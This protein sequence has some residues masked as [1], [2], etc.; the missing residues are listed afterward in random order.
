MGLLDTFV[1]SVQDLNPEWTKDRL[2]T[3]AGLLA[4]F[5]PVVGDIKAGYEMVDS[6]RHGNYGE[7]ALNG[8]GLL[9]F[10]P[11]MGGV[12][13]PKLALSYMPK[14]REFIAEAVNAIK[15]A[16]DSDIAKHNDY[17]LLMVEDKPG[18]KNVNAGVVAFD[19][20]NNP[21]GSMRYERK[22]S[23]YPPIVAVEEE[24]RR[25]GLATAMYDF[26]RTNRG[27]W[28]PYKYDDTGRTD[29]GDAFRKAYNK[30][31]GI[32]EKARDYDE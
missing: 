9:P 17:R 30:K 10:V 21:V 13:S 27:G 1:Q 3:A 15:N 24:H 6:A 11:A 22:N 28:L 29:M 23:E 5:T 19:A 16:P 7:A 25:K 20:N 26:A 12:L 32:K 2:K 4:D 14:D 18:V 8:I 31:R